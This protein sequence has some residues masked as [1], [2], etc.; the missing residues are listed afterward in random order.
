MT[1]ILNLPYY[2]A[3]EVRENDY[4]YL[5]IAQT[6]IPPRS[7]PTCQSLDFRRHGTREPI[8]MD[9]PI[10][11]KR[12]GVQVIRQR[13]RCKSCNGVFIDPIPDMDESRLMT[14]RLVRYIQDE[15]LKRTFTSIA[16]DVGV[17]ESTI[18]VVFRELVA[19]LETQYKIETPEWLGLD[20]LHILRKPRCVITNVKE[21]TLLDIL[22]VRTKPVVERY[23][24][25]MPERKKIEVVTMDMWKP[26]RE[27][28]EGC[29]PDARIVV[30]KF[31]VVKMVNKGLDEFRKSLKADMT[32]AQKR[33]LMRDR[34][35]LLRREK[36]LDAKDRLLLD[37]WTSN[38]PL[39]GQAH[40]L[41]EAFF[42]LYDLPNRQE[43]QDQYGLWCEAVEDLPQIAPYYS[44]VI[45]AVDNWYDQV[46]AFYDYQVTNA[47]TEAMNGLIKI[48]N[49]MGR[50]YSFEAIRAKM[51]FRKGRV[52]RDKP[53]FDRGKPT[54]GQVSVFEQPAEY[55]TP[56]S[57][58]VD[59]ATL[60]QEITDGHL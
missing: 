38:L 11:G 58:G 33:Q 50:G 4:D 2:R 25:Q 13:Y 40:I 54:L 36:D 42:N 23:L 44:D 49:R 18:R 35:I 8:F 53:K 30:D 45:R 12:A 19:R 16:E 46:F 3:L 22:K 51:L 47:Y 34:Y 6:T 28:V 10:H 20:E 32:N 5:I 43:A 24:L 41:K 48:A 56:A 29:L 37:V 52:V 9:V 1:D 17:D 55:S 57:P 31:H 26:Y 39:L 59:I 14:R 27:A 15:S 21:R 60:I 7:C